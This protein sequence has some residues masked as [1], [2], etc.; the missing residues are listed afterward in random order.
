MKLIDISGM[1]FGRLTV[2]AKAQQSRM[3]LCRCDCGQEAL[4]TGSGLRRGAR[5]SCGCR[6]IDWAREMGSRPDFIEKRSRSQAVHGGKRRGQV[7]PEYRTWLAIKRRCSDPKHKDYKNWGG[8]G[9]RVCDE[10]DKSFVRFLADMGERPEGFTIDR[11]DPNGDYRPGNC[12]WATPIEQVTEHRRSLLPM[13]FE[14]VHYKNQADLARA[15]SL[16]PGTLN[17]RLKAGVP[18]S[19]ALRATR[20]ELARLRPRESYLPSGHPDRKV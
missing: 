18:L 12:R 15:F 2:V 5:K 11:I 9:I 6:S 10:W 8:R 13:T 14:G 16:R 3:W 1:K 17:M 7:S 19:M 20:A 4:A